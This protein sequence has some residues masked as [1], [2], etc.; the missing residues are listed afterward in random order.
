[1]TGGVRYVS[2]VSREK[3]HKPR[4]QEELKWTN[5]KW[6]LQKNFQIIHC[7]SKFIQD[8]WRFT[9]YFQYLFVP[10]SG[11]PAEERVAASAGESSVDPEMNGGRDG[12]MPDQLLITFSMESWMCP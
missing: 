3:V 10:S 1:M 4:V 12:R 8:R 5:W 9:F 7:A 6:G 2:L 11:T